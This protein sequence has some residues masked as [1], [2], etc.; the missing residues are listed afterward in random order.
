MPKHDRTGDVTLDRRSFEEM[1]LM[2]G[3]QAHAKD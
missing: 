1:I 2:T 3:K